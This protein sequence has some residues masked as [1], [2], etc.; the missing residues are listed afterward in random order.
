MKK[1]AA[2]TAC[3]LLCVS[4]VSCGA[5]AG[6]NESSYYDRMEDNFYAETTAAN[7]DI[8]YLEPSAAGDNYKSENTGD[9]AGMPSANPVREEK[10]VYTANVTLESEDFDTASDALHQKIASLGGIIISENAYN[11]NGK[12]YGNRSMNMTVRIPQESYETFL[13]GL[14]DIC[15]VAEVNRYVENLTERYYD[16]ENRLKSYRIQEERLFAMLEKAESVT[17]MLEIESRLCDV[18]YQIEAL[19][20]TQRT[21]DNDVRYSTFNLT[22]AEVKKFTTPEPETFGDKFKEA[23]G[24]SVE[25]FGVFS[26]NLLFFFIYVLPYLL[27]IAVVVVI[28]LVIVKV[29]KKKKEKKQQ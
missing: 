21:I 15:N 13:T 14:S 6:K 16:N 23:V 19:T 18:Q 9:S 2:F 5:A 29:S 20:N 26:E 8:G 27:C 10:L 1:F 22:L 4:M 11:L 24:G 12:S 17:E 28:V 7:Y 3:L 25:S